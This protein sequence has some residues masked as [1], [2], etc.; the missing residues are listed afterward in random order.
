MK[1]I[2]PLSKRKQERRSVVHERPQA[3]RQGVTSGGWEAVIDLPGG[4]TWK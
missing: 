4:E 2:N 3:G 1:D